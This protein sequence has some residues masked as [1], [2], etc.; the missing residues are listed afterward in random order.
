MFEV[1]AIHWELIFFPLNT[2]KCDLGKVETAI[3]QFVAC[4]FQLIFG[5]L[6]TQNATWVSSKKRCFKGSHGTINLFWASG[7]A[8]NAI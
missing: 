3:F 1:V 6:V 4:H 2:P 7:L 8:Q 5:L